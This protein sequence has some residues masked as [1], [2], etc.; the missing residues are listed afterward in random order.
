MISTEY[1]LELDM[2]LWKGM[3]WHTF[4]ATSNWKEYTPKLDAK[5]NR[6][7]ASTVNPKAMRDQIAKS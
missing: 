6:P 7:T 3:V 1:K 2:F 5:T 4:R